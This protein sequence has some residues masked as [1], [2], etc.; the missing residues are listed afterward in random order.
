MTLIPETWCETAP[1]SDISGIRVGDIIGAMCPH[2]ARD[3]NQSY[4]DKE[5]SP[6]PLG[7]MYFEESFFI[8]D[9][10]FPETI[11]GLRLAK[12]GERGWQ[13]VREELIPFTMPIKR[14]SDKSVAH[15]CPFCTISY[16]DDTDIPWSGTNI[17]ELNYRSSFTEE[18]QVRKVARLE[19]EDFE[20]FREARYM[21]MMLAQGRSTAEIIQGYYS[22]EEDG[23]GGE[24]W[25]EYE[26]EEDE[27]DES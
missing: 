10:L 2:Y 4:A 21:A 27:E 23:E 14:D 22:E 11:A 7:P 3:E 5:L 6:S 9:T 13:E 20:S 26:E 16:T 8:V 15:P 24:E 12:L 17:V 25:E 19:P 18:N 1:P